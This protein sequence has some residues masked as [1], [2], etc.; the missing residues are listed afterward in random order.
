[1]AEIGQ[2]IRKAKELLEAG[3]LVAIPTE[4]VYGLSANGLNETALLEIYKVK[5]RPKFDPLIAHTDSLK[6]VESY[7]AYMPKQALAIADA[8][9]PGPLTLLLRKKS[10]VPDLLT[11]GLPAIA[12]RIPRHKLTLQLLASLDFP[13]AAPSANP[14]GYVSPTSAQHVE[15][16]LGKKIPYILDGGKCEVGIESTIIGFDEKENPVVY[17]LGGKKIED[18]ENVIGKVR[19]RLNLSSDPVAP[20]MLKSH[21]S[22]AKRMIVGRISDLLS[23]YKSRKIG[24]ISFSTRFEEVSDEYQIVLSPNRDMDQAA[25]HLFSAMRSLD[26]KDIDLILTEKFPDVGLGR[27][28]NDR[29]NRASIR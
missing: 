11:S 10:T 14:F 13:L 23:K 22:P 7:V 27:A 2:D 17:R 21:Y 26:N 28:I 9:W 29:L 15:D 5:N 19:L 1:M 8:F 18:I 3:K 16:Q 4:T 6:K 25:K 24:I 20:G 12:I